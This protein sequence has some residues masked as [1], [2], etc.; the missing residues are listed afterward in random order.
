MLKLRAEGNGSYRG[1]LVKYWFAGIMLTRKY[2]K[3]LRW[4][5]K[6]INFE[7]KCVL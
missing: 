1:K 7:K 5:Y 4:V 2:L 6:Y 3:K